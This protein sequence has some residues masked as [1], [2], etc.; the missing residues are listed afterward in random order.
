M[1]ALSFSDLPSHH[2][3]NVSL[4]CN[5]LLAAKSAAPEISD[6]A[7]VIIP[8]MPRRVKASQNIKTDTPHK[9]SYFYTLDEAILLPW[10]SFD[11]SDFWNVL[12]LDVDHANGMDLWEELPENLRPF[13]V[14][15]PYSLRSAALFLLKTPVLCTSVGQLALAELCSRVLASYF[16]ATALPHCSLTKNPFGLKK[17]LQGVL[18][19]RTAQPLGGDLWEMSQTSPLVFHT[20]PG[21]P[22]IELR[23]ILAHFGDDVDAVKRPKRTTFVE[24]GEP[25]DL[26][27]NCRLFDILRA[28][29]Y[30][31]GLKEVDEIMAEAIA[32]NENGLPESE[33]RSI[34]VS[35]SKFMKTRYRPRDSV[36]RSVMSLAAS[37]LPVKSK[38][39]LSAMRTNAVRTEN[40]DHKIAQALRHWPSGQ[41][42]SQSKLAKA[43]G[44][45]LTTIKRRWATLNLPR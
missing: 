16:N 37:S 39:K 2:R 44:V 22:G 36:N 41:P 13:L 40:A 28:F 34:S 45:N 6:I 12:A 15:D 32:L 23:E 33:L 20:L 10:I 19:R 27:R 11:A 29:C 18:Q 35:I 4:V 31:N 5:T 8:K 7:D 1:S 3:R 42:I 17:S 30:D 43:S 38:Q 14:I 26:G 25:S 24:R 9:C 21:S